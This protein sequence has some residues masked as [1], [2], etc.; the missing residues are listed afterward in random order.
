MDELLLPQRLLVQKNNQSLNNS[1][2]N[3]KI[4]TSS[5][6]KLRNQVQST[7]IKHLSLL[8]KAEFGQKYI[9]NYSDEK[10]HNSASSSSIPITLIDL[11]TERK[12]RIEEYLTSIDIITLGMTNKILYS[13]LKLLQYEVIIKFHHVANIIRCGGQFGIF[14]G[15]TITIGDGMASLISS[16][17]LII[18][19]R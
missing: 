1:S 17:L 10:L 18:W 16:I 8:E 2:S 4:P 9:Q 15:C 3:K 19:N 14:E 12:F 5:V 13:F 7:K 11:I 6:K